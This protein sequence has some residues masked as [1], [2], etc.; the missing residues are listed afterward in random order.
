MAVHCGAH[1]QIKLML[2]ATVV[3]FFFPFWILFEGALKTYILIPHTYTACMIRIV[4]TFGVVHT[5][6]YGSSYAHHIAFS[7]LFPVLVRA[8]GS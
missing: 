5:C 6:W 2:A 1:Q 8:L 7:V 4:H 3:K